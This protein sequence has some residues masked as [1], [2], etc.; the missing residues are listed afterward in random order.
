V[1]QRVKGFVRRISNK[2]YFGAYDYSFTDDVFWDGSKEGLSSL[3]EYLILNIIKLSERKKKYLVQPPIFQ[4]SVHKSRVEKAEVFARSFIGGSYYLKSN[5]A[6]GKLLS[7]NYSKI[8]EF[9]K[10]GIVASFDPASKEY[11]GVHNHL[12]IENTSIIIG[13]MVSEGLIWD[14]YSESDKTIILNY[15]ETYLHAE[16]YENNWVWFKIFHYLFLEK[17][18]GKDFCYEITELLVKVKK[19]MLGSGWFADGY[20]EKGANIDYYSAWA[21]H[22]YYSIFRKYS[23]G[24]YSGPLAVFESAS[25]RFSQSYKYF[26]IPG[27]THP[28]LG[29]SQLYR[30]AAL[31]PFGYFIEDD[32]YTVSELGYLKL[33]FM[34]EINIFLKNGAVSQGGYL[35][36][37]I[38]APSVASLEHYS[39]SGSPYWALKAFSLLM[40]SD[41]SCFWDMSHENITV[42][43]KVIT[44]AGN[45]QIL[46]RS[47]SGR[48]FLLDGYNTSKSYGLKYNKFIYKNI[49]ASD[50]CRDINWSESSIKISLGDK[51]LN[52]M[53]II[54][55]KCRNGKGYIKWAFDDAKGLA[56]ESFYIMLIDGYMF[57]HKFFNNSCEQFRCGLYGLSSS[58]DSIK[59]RVLDHNIENIYESECEE[60]GVVSFFIK[61]K[62]FI[63]AVCLERSNYDIST[64][65]NEHTFTEGQFF[66]E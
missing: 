7:N 53:N 43:D 33:S 14:E 24:R 39:G 23:G 54:Q 38:L 15:L 2:Y 16:I 63:T 45:K 26:F 66:G 28:V 64:L 42:E 65:I 3:C 12:I 10:K 59:L 58:S 22:Y 62:A 27:G 25:A 17:H 40:V 60:L 56:I 47:S 32:Y 19:M 37:G 41:K 61:G 44:L 34:N 51:E 18:C 5:S 49:K 46:S 30:F 13:L 55:S 31:A 52:Q 4:K 1:K 35:T 9:Y 48:I 57:H 20:P 29:R 36:M 50:D 6:G 21:F 8:L 11:W